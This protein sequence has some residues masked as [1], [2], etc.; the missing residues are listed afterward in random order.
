MSIRHLNLWLLFFSSRRRHTRYWRDWSSDVC[1]S[2]LAKETVEHERV[3][4]FLGVTGENPV[5]DF[6]GRFRERHGGRETRPDSI[7]DRKIVVMG[8]RVDLVGRRFIKK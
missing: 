1:S 8:K 2:D 3:V 7:G 5:G 6:L 4:S